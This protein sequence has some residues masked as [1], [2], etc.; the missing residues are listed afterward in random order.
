MEA[1]AP[2]PSMAASPPVFGTA[3]TSTAVLAMAGAAAAAPRA[4]LFTI[5]RQL[6]RLG[7]CPPHQ[8]PAGLASIADGTFYVRD[9]MA[10][11]GRS[12]GYTEADIIDA[13]RHNM[14]HEDDPAGALRF[15]L[16]GDDQAGAWIKI[17]PSRRKGKGKVASK[18]SGKA[19]TR[20]QRRRRSRS[21]SRGRCFRRSRSHSCARSWSGDRRRRRSSRGSSARREA[22]DRRLHDSRHRGLGRRGSRPQSHSAQQLCLAVVKTEESVRPSA[23]PTY[24]MRRPAP[25]PP[26]GPGWTQYQ[27]GDSTWWH[28]AGPPGAPEWWCEAIGYPIHRF[29]AKA[30][31]AMP[32]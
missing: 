2:V 16:G 1:M 12:Q 19:K 14:V 10:S 11:W 31:E 24:S 3:A 21:D 27:D 9:L 6:V 32:V 20:D 22:Y 17:F 28:Y 5:S 29:T 15:E 30:S 7:R 25:P 18:G 26:P 23:A 4:N 8:R 13:V